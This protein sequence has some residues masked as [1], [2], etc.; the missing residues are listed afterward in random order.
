MQPIDELKRDSLD[1]IWP[2]KPVGIELSHFW[3]TSC[4]HKCTD[5]R[6]KF[7]EREEMADSRMGWWE[8]RKGECHDALWSA[9]GVRRKAVHWH[10]SAGEHQATFA[11]E[12][13]S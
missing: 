13:I 12:E 2:M 9:S 1:K 7:R 8:R 3:P 4:S 11:V 6:Q 5:G 10:G